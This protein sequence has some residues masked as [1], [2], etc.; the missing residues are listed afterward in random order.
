MEAPLIT[1][2]IPELHTHQ[3]VVLQMFTAV[4][5]RRTSSDLL[6]DHLL[7]SAGAA[8]LCCFWKLLEISFKMLMN[9]RFD[10]YA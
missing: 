4:L 3:T 9:Q 6:I 7:F 2:Q 1:T 10:R 8:G 5:I